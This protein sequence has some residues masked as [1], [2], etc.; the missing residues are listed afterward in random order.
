MLDRRALAAPTLV[1][2]G[3]CVLQSA[4]VDE[5][6]ATATA[7]TVSATTSASATTTGSGGAGG[8]GSTS[9][10]VTGTGGAGGEGGQGGTGAGGEG[11][12][13]GAGGAGGGDGGAGGAG[14]GDGGAGGG[15]LFCDPADP[16]LVACWP[17]END[18]TDA[19]G[20]GHDASAENVFF[21]PH[22]GQGFALA[23]NDTSLVKVPDA[24]EWD[25][26]AVTVEVWV[27]PIVLPLAGERFGI[28]DSNDRYSVF[29]YDTGEIRCSFGANLFGGAIP[30]NAWTHVAC[31]H[32]GATVALFVNGAMVASM[33]ASPLPAGS[34]P[35]SIGSNLPEEDDRFLGYLD[36][37][38]FFDV[39]RSDQEICVAAGGC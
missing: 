15:P 29:L 7:T 34:S 1:A 24:Q 28:L 27:H 23:L 38:R 5:G 16:T 6:G 4:G 37:L 25:V 9:T 14:G 13:G 17:F 35:V 8:T 18:V 19:S 3:A 31:T 21:V 22:P 36:G 12:A 2:L 11:G 33:E 20:H 30:A 39:R 32:D 26:S 10:D